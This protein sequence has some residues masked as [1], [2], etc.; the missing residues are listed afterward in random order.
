MEY[1]KKK[2]NDFPYYRNDIEY[3][4]DYFVIIDMMLER[5]QRNEFGKEGDL[6]REQLQILNHCIEKMQQQI[7][8]KNRRSSRRH[9]KFFL[10]QLAASYHL[11]PTEKKIIVFLLYRYVNN[12]N[13]G[14]SGRTILE[15]ITDNRLEMMRSRHYLTENSKLC[16]HQLVQFQENGIECSVF[17]IEYSLPEEI[18]SR[19]LGEKQ[20]KC[21]S[22]ELEQKE[23]K[24]YKNY[25]NLHFNLVQLMEK[26]AELLSIIHSDPNP[27]EQLAEI[28]AETQ[29]K[30]LSQIRHNIRKIGNTLKNFEKESENY[31]L[32]KVV[33]EYQL[34]QEEKLLLVILLRDSLGL[35]DSFIGCEG[36]KLLAIIA[37]CENEMIGKRSLLYKESR[38]RKNKLVEMEKVWG[39]QNILD[40]EYFLSEKMIRRLLGDINEECDTDDEMLEWE[41][42]EEQSILLTI[43]PRF[44]FSDVILNLAKKE[45]IRIALSQQQHHRL[46]FETWGF[47]HKIPY[48]NALT[49]LFSGPPGTGKT[50]MAEGIARELNKKL[51]IAN[52]ARI[53]NMYV[54]ETEKRIVAAFKK[55]K[56]EDG[57]LLWDEADSMFYSRDFAGHSW[58][59]RD[60]NVILQELEK[61]NGVV[62]L[63]TN[64]PVV[65]DR[66]LE[67]RISLK[68]SF[69]MPDA[70]ER[71]QIWR[72]LIPSQAPL[73][74][75]VD[76]G[77]LAN[78]HEVAGGIIKNAILN[79]ARYAAYQNAG[80]I[81]LAH[82]EYGIKMEQENNWNQSDKI[83]FLRPRD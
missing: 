66:A 14:T 16:H 35:S 75:D 2:N 21:R 20:S 3:I 65:L 77:Y 1:P 55:A 37:G 8:R 68:V 34:N 41:P 56:E 62:I 43:T 7:E 23:E 18:I 27:F 60:V 30:E 46:I 49:M 22:P 24:S 26:R 12:D 67:R 82:F 25:L 70:E 80:H 6:F 48:G 52:Y 74:Q 44:A 63:T 73:A 57:L 42:E 31:P 17:D 78:K 45:T 81:A 19:L 36:K 38:L 53:Q 29:N 50:M 58:E 4:E 61:F 71:E 28:D 10:D 83:G 64:R 13:L 5:K 59:F 40:G 33:A 9:K 15:S 79:A 11:N 51:L 72:Q 54:G 39:G 47:V 76:F 32:E 69:D